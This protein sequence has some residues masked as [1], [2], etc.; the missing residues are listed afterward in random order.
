MDWKNDYNK[1]VGD[2]N[3]EKDSKGFLYSDD[4]GDR[5]LREKNSH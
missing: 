4:M 3:L 2:V 1:M 5:Q